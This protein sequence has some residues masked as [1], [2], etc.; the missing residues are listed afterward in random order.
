MFRKWI[1]PSDR[2]LGIFLQIGLEVVRA[3][4]CQVASFSLAKHVLEFVIFFWDVGK[5]NQFNFGGESG[6]RRRIGIGS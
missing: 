5:V 6:S 1:H 4:W 2:R 3:V